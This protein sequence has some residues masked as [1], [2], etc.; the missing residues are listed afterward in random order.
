MALH[1]EGGYYA[2]YSQV[3]HDLDFDAGKAEAA[4]SR[5]AA[6]LYRIAEEQGWTLTCPVTG[7]EVSKAPSLYGGRLVRK[8]GA[9][10]AYAHDEHGHE[11]AGADWTPITAKW[12]PSQPLMPTRERERLRDQFRREA[13]RA[14]DSAKAA[15]KA[16]A[17]EAARAAKEAQE[18]ED[19][20]NSGNPFAC[21]AALK[22]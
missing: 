2:P 5:S 13:F 7:Q 9:I 22:R 20:R 6:A 12:L 14:E 10:V 21:L 16:A 19:F 17:E 15:A 8:D 4:R 1:T 11:V 18:R 3:D